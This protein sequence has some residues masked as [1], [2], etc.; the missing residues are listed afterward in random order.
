MSV[1]VTACRSQ[2]I[3]R[4]KHSSDTKLLY[5][6]RSTSNTDFNNIDVK[7]PYFLVILYF[8]FIFVLIPPCACILFFYC[9]WQYSWVSLGVHHA[10]PSG[11]IILA[12][13]VKCQ[14]M[15][16]LGMGCAGGAWP[17]VVISRGDVI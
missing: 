4:L 9:W 6:S 8:P 14:D 16:G 10:C 3:I 13:V 12:G 1:L 2:L 7:N 17:H 15:S 5:I 11:N